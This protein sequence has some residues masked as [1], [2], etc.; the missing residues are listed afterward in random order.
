MNTSM[1]L[2]LRTSKHPDAGTYEVGVCN[3]WGSPR[4]KDI[5]SAPDEETCERW[6]EH[7]EAA[8][9]AFL[10]AERETKRRKENP[11]PQQP[12]T[13]L[14]NDPQE[15]MIVLEDLGYQVNF[16]PCGPGLGM[17]AFNPNER[18]HPPYQPSVEIVF[19]WERRLVPEGGW[20]HV[21]GIEPIECGTPALAVQR[22]K[23][24]LTTE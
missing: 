12:T 4:I 2:N 10:D 14:P 3:I 23:D 9:L 8:H 24:R 20:V 19:K 17:E 15:L 13:D 16:I 11:E 5:F 18:H 6:I 22:L 1:H 7:M 21:H